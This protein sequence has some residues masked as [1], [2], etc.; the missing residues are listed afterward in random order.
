MVLQREV[1]DDTVTIRPSTPADVP[2]LIGG[3]DVEFHRFLGDGSP[4]PCPLAC[5][6]VNGEVVGWVD[7]DHERTWLAPD[8]VNL[9]YNVFP[10]ARGHGYATRAVRLLLHH[11]AVDTTWLVASLLIHPDNE[12]SLTLAL[13]LSFE[14]NGDLDGSRY[15]KQNVSAYTVIGRWPLP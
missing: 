2:T 8:E 6:V 14:P 4:E 1:S 7:F 13:R 9:G 10:A 15:L 5:I 12:R 11:L 3:R